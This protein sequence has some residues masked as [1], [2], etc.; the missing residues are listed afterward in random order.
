M[1]CGPNAVSL[2]GS[3]TIDNCTCPQGYFGTGGDQSCTGNIT[4]SA[5]L[6]IHC[7]ASLHWPNF[8]WL[9]DD[10]STIQ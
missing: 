8:D 5:S 10:C 2:N 7:I 3:I 4:V 9:I 6:L 1:A